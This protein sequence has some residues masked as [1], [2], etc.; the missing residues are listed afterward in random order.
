MG[1]DSPGGIRLLMVEI[2][3]KQRGPVIVH[4]LIYLVMG[5]AIVCLTSVVIDQA[6]KLQSQ[7]IVI[8]SALP[9][10]ADELNLIQF[11]DRI[12]LVRR[13][14][15]TN[16]YEK[17]L[18]R[19]EDGRMH[20]SDSNVKAVFG[21]DVSYAQKDIDWRKVKKAGVEFAMLRIGFRGYGEGTIV[22]DNRFERNIREASEAGIDVGV[23]FFSQALNE[24]E[25]RE[26]ALW[27]ID[28][29][30]DYN[31]T[32]PV[33]FDWEFYTNIPEARSN[34]MDGETLTTCALAFSDEIAKAGYTPMIYFNMSLGYLYY[35]L[36]E[37]TD[38]HFWL[39]EL[40]GPPIFYYNFQMLQYSHTG[41]V[42]GIEGDVDL[43]L[44]FISFDE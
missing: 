1:A 5:F 34:N 22:Q 17:D 7:E 11:R 20:Y 27:V 31:I 25:A 14:V 15:Q 42:E 39:A 26:E 6:A 29:L 4:L 33:V 2:Y 21:I 35:D 44:C 13:N 3:R 8:K 41:K 24:K 32:Y 19:I 36:S 37:I 43:N 23:Y 16:K 40:N 12:I 10:K 18:F 9:Q 28:V 30:K 38:Y